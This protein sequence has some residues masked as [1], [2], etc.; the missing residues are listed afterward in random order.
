M[1]QTVNQAV[2]CGYLAQAPAFSHENHGRKFFRFLLEVPRL[3]GTSDLRPCLVPEDVLQKTELTDGGFL[4][5]T[6]QVRSFNSR[7]E[8]GRRLLISVY[9]E[10]IEVC[11]DPPQNDI[12]LTGAVC[13]APAARKTPLGREICDLMLAVSRRC[14]RTDYIPC[15]L[16]GRTAREAAEL[17]VGTKLEIHGRLQSRIYRK[18]L[19]E[20]IEERVTY[21][22]SAMEAFL[23]PDEDKSF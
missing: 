13:R 9:T 17:P 1:E 22:L 5:V 19:D 20:R 12:V 11:S 18:V 21:E 23:L 15:I 10:Q 3:S 2:L 6:G 4:R 16:W 7:G 14:R 8:E